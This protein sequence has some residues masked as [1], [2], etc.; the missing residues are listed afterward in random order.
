MRVAISG[1]PIF[2]ELQLVE[3]GQVVEHAAARGARR[4]RAGLDRYSTGSPTERNLTPWYCGRQEAAAPQ[5]IV[6]RLVVGVAAAL[7]DHDHEGG[8][9]LVLAAQAVGQPGAMLGRPASCAP[10]WKKVMAGSWL[11]ASVCI[12]LTKHSSSATFAVC[13]SSSLSQAPLLP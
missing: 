1:S 4:R 13:G 5:A 8:Q 6:E 12:D 10:V 11:M 3:P 9:V 2:F 7:R